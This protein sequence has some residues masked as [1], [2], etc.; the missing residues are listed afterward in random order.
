MPRSSRGTGGTPWDASPVPGSEAGCLGHPGSEG[1]DTARALKGEGT[2]PGAG[3]K[4]S[5]ETVRIISNPRVPVLAPDREPLMPAKASRVRGWIKEGKARPVR[6]K[7]GIFA[8]QLL[9]EPSGRE[10]QQIAVGIDPGSKYTGVAV[11]SS[12]AIL[13]GFNLELPDH[14]KERMDKRRERRRNRR[15]RKCRRRKCRF[16][17]RR[18][19]KIAPSILARKQL[20]LRVVKELAKIYP[21]SIIALEDVSFDHRNKRNGKYFSHVE[22]GKRWLISALERIAFVELFKG[23]ETS[24]RRKELGLKKDVRKE[25]RTPEAHVSDA[26]ALCSLV[27]GDIRITPFHFDVVRRPKYS[28]RMLHAEQPAKGGIRR[29]YGGTTTPFIFRKGDYVEAMQRGRVVR[30][31][32]SG[33][34]KHLISVSDFEWKRLGQFAVSNVRLLE[35][36][37]R[38]LLKS[39]EVRGANSSHQCVFARLL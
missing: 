18:G 31:W 12:G 13:C 3:G 1:G 6:T 14:I 8:V 39:K 37:T 27:L 33:H 30:G 38:L 5:P 21:I 7:L 19:H 22:I 15:Y 17:N 25:N 34:T 9:E 11:A 23:W 2:L 20:E 4:H 24:Q 26:V 10:K 35:R 32:V 29:P 28:R 36:N 16:L